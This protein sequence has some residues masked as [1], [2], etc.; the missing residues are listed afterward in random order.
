MVKT[1]MTIKKLKKISIG[2]I[3]FMIFLECNMGYSK[4]D[5]SS[6]IEPPPV[7][8][9]KSNYSAIKI[10]MGNGTCEYYYVFAS[11]NEFSEYNQSFV[12]L[13]RF[14]NG[15]VMNPHPDI[16]YSDCSY[17]VISII[18][19]WRL[20][21]NWTE[22]YFGVVCVNESSD[23]WSYPVISQKMSIPEGLEPPD[24]DPVDPD[25]VDPDPTPTPTS[26][27][28][29]DFKPIFIILG[30]GAG[31]ILLA[32]VANYIVIHLPPI[33]I[34]FLKKKKNSEIQKEPQKTSQTTNIIREIPIY[35][36]KV[37]EIIYIVENLQDKYKK[38]VWDV[39]KK[40]LES[41]KYISV[42]DFE[43][44]NENLCYFFNK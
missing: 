5:T 2:I 35:K 26:P 32:I 15:R 4:A 3:L 34:N 10:T 18:N 30:A 38:A 23:L 24:P 41:K 28:F 8:V 43:N 20:P 44:V 6:L 37:D 25:P 1:I 29:E 31:L 7:C 12:R 36:N 17:D 40:V 19:Y 14:Y 42:K 21:S 39:F 11:P 22:C 13:E 16:D 27:S 33:S 9:Y